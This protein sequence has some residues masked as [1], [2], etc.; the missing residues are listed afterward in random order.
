MNYYGTYVTETIYVTA[1]DGIH[2]IELTK[3]GDDPVFFV[4]NCCN[5][6][7]VWAFDLDMSNYELVKHTIMD[8]IL[9][10]DDMDDLMDTLDRMFGIVF[11][12]IIADCEIECGCD[13]DNG[14]NHCGC[15]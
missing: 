3:S 4:T 2:Y 15:M 5:E 10:C 14:C 6:D 1:P 12:D 11:G 7:W 9:S 13:C 8:T